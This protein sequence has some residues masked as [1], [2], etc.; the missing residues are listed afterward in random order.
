[1]PA[2]T[3]PP[4]ARKRV[5]VVGSGIAGLSAA[6]LLSRRHA[7]TVFE[8]E[9]TVGMDAHSLDFGGARMDIP[10]RVFSESYYPNLCNIYNLL[11][12]KYRVA[13]YAF[14]I[15]KSTSLAAYFRYVN[16]FVAGMAL[17]LAGVVA[18]ASMLRCW[19]LAYEF[20][21]FVRYSPGYLVADG[22]DAR[23]TLKAFL[24]KH[25]YSRAFATELLLP[26][27]SVVCTCAAPAARLP[28]SLVPCARPAH[29]GADRLLAPRQVLVR[30]R[31]RL[32]RPDRRR[33][34]CRQVR[35]LGGAV[36][37]LRRDARRRGSP[38]RARRARGHVGKGG[39]SVRRRGSRPHGRER[40]VD[41]RG[42]PPTL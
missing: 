7:V 28:R 42:G 12:V 17:P 3:A 29:R 5:A 38:H 35:A 24:E 40:G 23:L 26:M 36:P 6:W 13:D 1:M 39:G 15:A 30:C 41:R 2:D 18:P 32:P 33:L 10:L 22:P 8:R 4:D 9:D 14:C 34:L 11:G 27:L 37:R 21:H 20:A 25:R 16:A 19:S 31:G